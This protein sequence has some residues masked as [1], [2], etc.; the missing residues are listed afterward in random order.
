MLSNPEAR[1]RY[2]T[3]RMG[4]I[5]GSAS[6]GQGETGTPTTRRGLFST[7]R[8]IFVI[9]LIF[10]A[11]PYIFRIIKNPKALILIAIAIAVAW[12]GPRIVRYFKS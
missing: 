10:A 5:P 11:L 12:F 1:A 8:S 9:V 7:V 4:R 6:R 2:D 3:F